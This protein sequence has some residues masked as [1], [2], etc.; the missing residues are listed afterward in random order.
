MASPL[1]APLPVIFGAMTFGSPGVEQARVHT[2]LECAAI[3]DIFQAHGHTEID[4]ARTYCDGT[5]ESLLGDLDWQ[6]RG[7]IMQTK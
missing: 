1:K 5:S 7:L 4:T 3:L 6:G 2:I